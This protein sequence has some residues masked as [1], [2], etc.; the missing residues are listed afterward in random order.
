MT[1]HKI[2]IGMCK[3]VIVLGGVGAVWLTVT[4]PVRATAIAATCSHASH[5]AAK[6]SPPIGFDQAQRC[7]L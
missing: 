6:A 5:G 2:I 4:L 7:W 1:P 3:G